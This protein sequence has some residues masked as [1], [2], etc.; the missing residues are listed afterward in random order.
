MERAQPAQATVVV[1]C[2]KRYAYS[3]LDFAKRHARVPVKQAVISPLALSLMYRANEIEGYSR[4]QL[5]D[6]LLAA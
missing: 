1:S 2:Y 6:D 5:I 3:F 4:E